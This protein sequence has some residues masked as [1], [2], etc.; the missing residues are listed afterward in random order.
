MKVLVP[1]SV[2]RHLAAEHSDAGSSIDWA[3]DLF[4]GLCVSEED[5]MMPNM[6]TSKETT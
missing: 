2:G 5:V 1:L 4:Q 3:E 6:K